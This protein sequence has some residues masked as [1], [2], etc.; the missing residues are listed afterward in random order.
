MPLVCPARGRLRAASR[1]I[2]PSCRAVSHIPSDLWLRQVMPASSPL[3]LP[4]PIGR[5]AVT[6]GGGQVPQDRMSSGE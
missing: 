6:L 2:G 1:A 4:S 3:C 5:T